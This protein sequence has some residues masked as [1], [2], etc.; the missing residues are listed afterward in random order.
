MGETGM[1]M[2][3]RDGVS[4]PFSPRSVIPRSAASMPPKK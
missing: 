2:Q 3:F 4:G 1:E